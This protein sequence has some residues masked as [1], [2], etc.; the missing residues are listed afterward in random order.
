MSQAL[1]IGLGS[2]FKD[3]CPR[4]SDDFRIDLYKQ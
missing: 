3:Y 2:S 1:G 4:L